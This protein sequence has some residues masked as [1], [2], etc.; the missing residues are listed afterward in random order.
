MVWELEGPMPILYRSNRLVVMH[1]PGPGTVH[2]HGFQYS[3]QRVTCDTDLRSI[4]REAFSV[5]EY[6]IAGPEWIGVN[7][8][9]LTAV[10]P[11]GA[12]R[13]KALGML[14]TMLAERFGFQ[15]HRERKD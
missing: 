13:E 3:G 8:Y 12:E 6:Q 2:M 15:Y 14:R 5:K 4:I 9:E 7:T 1:G 10:M 11:A